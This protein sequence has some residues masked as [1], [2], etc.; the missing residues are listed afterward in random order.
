MVVLGIDAECSV[1]PT[2]VRPVAA[3]QLAAVEGYVIVFHIKLDERRD[4]ILPK[5][6]KELLENVQVLLVKYLLCCV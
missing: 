6:L 3:M 4:G 2:G 5:A 1:R